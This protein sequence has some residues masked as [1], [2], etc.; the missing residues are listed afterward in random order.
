MITI[1]L[2]LLCSYLLGS[3]PFGL[4]LAYIVSKQDIR[5]KGSGNI[6]A[7]N[8]F[9][10]AGKL[11][12]LLTLILDLLKGAIAAIMARELVPE[13]E[14]ISY[15]AGFL[16]FLGHVY[17]IWLGFNGGKGVATALGVTLV[18]YPKLAFIAIGIWMTA[19]LLFRIVSF[20]SVFTSAAV[21][22]AVWL[23]AYQAHYNLSYEKSFI[24]SSICLIVIIRHRSNIKRMLNNE[25]KKL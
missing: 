17:P 5:Q 4:I 9:R 20:A 24:I 23:S 18:L 2:L 19:F 6:G 1:Y 10:V 22:I 14:I 11:V 25:E 15:I 3:I 12:G 8:A 13:I 16:T 7:T 21:I